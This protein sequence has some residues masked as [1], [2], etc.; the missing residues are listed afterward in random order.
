MAQQTVLHS[1]RS[2]LPLVPARE[3]KRFILL[4]ALALFMSVI[5][6]AL[7]G[8]VALLAATFGSPEAVLNKNPVLWLRTYMGISFGQDPR[9]LA[10]AVLSGILLIIV[11][12]NIFAVLQQ[13]HASCFSEQTALAARMHIFRFYQRAPYLWVMQR[14]VA[15]LGFG[16]RALSMLAA[17]LTL[18][19]QI[20]S[21]SLTLVILFIGLISVSPLP[22]L[23]FLSV[24]GLGGT[25][26]IKLTRKFIDRA[27]SAVYSADHKI[28]R[29]THLALH[30][31][32]EMRIYGRENFLFS[33]YKAQLDDGCTAKVKQQTTCRYPA[34]GT[35]ILGFCTLVAVMCLLVFVMDASI[36]RI[37]GIMG[38][39]A[40]TAWRGL[41]MMNRLA[42]SLSAVRGNLPYLHKASELIALEASL[43]PKLLALPEAACSLPF[44]RDI[45]L[46]G[47]CFRYPQ[48]TELAMDNISLCIPAGSMVG[49]VGLSGA[50][51]STLVNV[52]TGLIP[53]EAGQLRVD[54]TPVT[55]DNSASWL[56]N[57]GYVAQSPYI[58]DASLAENVALSRWGEEIDRERVIE[59]CRMAAL[60]FLDDL[61]KGIDTLLGERGTRLSGGQA[62][63]IAIAR[64]L[65]S[66]PALII[67]DEA[68][69]SL[70][71]K[72]EKAIHETI[73][74]LRD[75]V[76]MVI[77]AHR[78][79]SIEGCDKL[80]WLKKGRVHAVGCM[81]DVLPEYKATLEQSESLADN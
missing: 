25:L 40:A 61:E 80:V 43:A 65:Y 73:L 7:T 50:G 36:A 27:S 11:S 46:D 24:L 33:T 6:L 23:L 3:K 9:L 34:C 30:G 74:S 64:A 4:I 71:I 45:V 60:D 29:I 8:M 51:K 76:T 22:S 77:I 18:V 13:K 49:I 55:K 28:T 17:T 38:F 52:L 62:Q 78:L 35:E 31:L 47:V 48:A 42:D 70:D 19:L 37:S 58:L 39:M 56:R 15:E 79:S 44:A 54:G 41:P 81:G 63:R 1:L 14:G 20:F 16:I 12:K 21:N 53:P 59:C 66:E 67:F 68:T 32:K 26:V 75:T 10:L 72:N 5:E 69:S 57:I 2:L